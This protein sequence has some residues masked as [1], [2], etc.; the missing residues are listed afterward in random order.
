MVVAMSALKEELRVEVY[1]GKYT[2][3]FMS[4]GALS[5]RRYGQPWRDETGNGCLLALAQ[6][7]QNLRDK[8]AVYEKA[9]DEFLKLA[10]NQL[11]T[12]ELKKPN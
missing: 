11:L 2:V 3:I 12:N 7:V 1:D 6:E 8:L 5:I 4:N 10:S 9:R